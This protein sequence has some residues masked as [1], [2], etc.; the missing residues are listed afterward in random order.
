VIS[1]RT[2]T[3]AL[4]GTLVGSVRFVVAETKPPHLVYIWFGMA[5]SDGDTLKGF[6]VGLH[7]IGYREGR[8]ILVDY[9]YADGNEKRLADLAAAAVAEQPDVIVTPG[10]A[11]TQSV[12]KLTATIPIVSVSG[13]PAG[14]GFI[15]SLARPGGNITGLTIQ[16]GPDLA[17]KWLELLVEIVPRARHIAFLRNALNLVAPAELVLMRA[18][19]ER[20][21]GNFTI[22]DYPVRGT[23]E[24]P[25]IFATML[26]TKPDALIVDNDPLLVSKAADV[27]PLAAG[28][29][30]ISAGRD[31][32]YAGGLLTYGASSFDVWR[33]AGSYI[34]RILKGA[35]PADLPV[36]QPTKFELVIN[37]KTAKALGLSVPQSLLA[38]A[39]EVIE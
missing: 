1:R 17:G 11:V 18:A 37:L 5:G 20:Q 32:A 36:E 13:D 33:R 30:V 14:S 10:S 23:A 6:Q 8:D 25:S 19:A 2:F 4:G 26:R 22:D 31:F 9:R 29:P 15:A 38:G 35:K 3:L 27:V 28:L 12:A 7:E 34:D 16:V 24:L 39:D 21:G